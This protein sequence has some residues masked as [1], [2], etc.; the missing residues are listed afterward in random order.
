M[1]GADDGCA[2][3]LDLAA[4][5]SPIAESAFHIAGFGLNFHRN[6]F[7][8]LENPFCIAKNTIYLLEIAAKTMS[9]VLYKTWLGQRY[10]LVMQF[11]SS[12]V[13]TR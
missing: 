1:K 5:P 8:S 6:V 4:G 7:P 3:M 10:Y 2:A 13:A 9:Y 11:A 12:V